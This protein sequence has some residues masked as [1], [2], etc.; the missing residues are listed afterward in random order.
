MKSVLCLSISGKEVLLSGGAD[1]VIILWDVLTGQKLHVLRGG[2]TRGVLDLA[3]DPLTYPIES[4][5]SDVVLFSAGSD[6]EIRRWRIS[7]DI[8]HAREIERDKVI[9]QH[10]TG[11]Y[12]LVF[13]AD[14]D[15]WT[16]SADGTAKRISRAQQFTSDTTLP[17]GDYVRSVAIDERGGY[18][19]TVGRDEDVKIWDSA[20]GMLCHTYSGHFEEITGCV[21]IGQNAV[22]VSIDATIRQWSLLAHDLEKAKQEAE[23]VNLRM[24]EEAVIVCDKLTED[25]DRELAE[26]MDN[27]E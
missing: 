18:V 15:L 11:V 22:T 24:A 12:R 4:A 26:L 23:K 27:D 2:H 7:S 3:V 5:E 9:I 20:S 14:D 16:A 25:E 21:V 13:D 6:R 17:H 10:E 8:S 19:V 1:A